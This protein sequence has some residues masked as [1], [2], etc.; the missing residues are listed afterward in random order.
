MMPNPVPPWLFGWMTHKLLL[1]SA[2]HCGRDAICFYL[3]GI[4]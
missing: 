4:E 1:R 3:N 2:T